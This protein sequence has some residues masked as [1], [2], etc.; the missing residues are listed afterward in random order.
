MNRYDE[1]RR[2]Q[3]AEFNSLPLKAAF[4]E[5]QF[6]EMMKEW[7][8]CHGRNGKPSDNDI[9]QIAHIYA[10]MYIQKKDI[11]LY[12]EVRARH[13]AEMQKAIAEDLTGEGFIYEMFYSELANHEY[14]YTGD[15]E[16]TLDCL[17]Y[18]YDD[19]HKDERLMN[20]LTKAKK[21]IMQEAE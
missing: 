7:G 1:L 12:R 16:E 8:L 13:D 19:I 3:Q 2:K 20:G 6:I 5:R 14:G 4:G 18:T 9:K 15:S 10:G 21:Q 11:P 17:G